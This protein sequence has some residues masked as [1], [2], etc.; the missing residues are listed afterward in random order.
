MP[1]PRPPAARDRRGPASRWWS[2]TAHTPRKQY[3][4]T[5]N[6]NG[7]WSISNIDVSALD[8]GPLTFT[9]TATDDQ[10]HSAEHSKT[11]TKDTVAPEVNVLGVTDPINSGNKTTTHANGTTDA[12]STI[13]VTAT[14]GTNTTAA[15]TGTAGD[16][17]TWSVTDIDVS[18]LTDGEI[19]YTIT[20]TDPAGN[21]TTVTRTATKDT[22]APTVDIDSVTDPIDLAHANSVTI[23][24][25][26]EAGATISVVITDGTNSTTATTTTVAENG[27]W[28]VSGINVSTLADGTITYQV[29]ITDGAF[30]TAQATQTAVKKTVSL[31]VVT[32]PVNSTN[33]T[34][35][36]ASGTGEAGATISLVVTDGTNT[37]QAYTTTIAANGTWSITGINVSSLADG[38]ITYRVTATDDEDNSAQSTKTATKDT[39]APTVA[40]TTVTN[41]ITSA[42]DNTVTIGGTGNRGAIDHRQSHRR[43]Q[44]HLQL[45]RHRGQQRHLGA[46]AISTSVPWPTAPSLS[47]PPPPTPRAT[48]PRAAITATK[49]AK[50]NGSLSGKVFVDANDNGTLDSGEHG[51][52]GV[53]VTLNGTDGA[54]NALPTQT[55]TTGA[56]RELSILGPG[57]RHLRDHSGPAA[58]GTRRRHHGRHPGRHRQ[59]QRDLGHLDR[60]HR[61]RH[62]IQLWR[63]RPVD[64]LCLDADVP[65]VVPVRHHPLQPRHLGLRHLGAVVTSIVKAST[66]PVSGSSVTFTVTFNQAVTG[67]DVSDFAIVASSGITGASI[68]SVTGSGTTYT[69]TVNVGGG[70]G[71]IGL[72]LADNDSIIDA[73]SSPLG[74]TGSGNGTFIGPSYTIASGVADAAISTVTSP[75]NNSQQGERLGQRHRRARRHDLVDRDRRH[76]YDQC[77]HGHGRGQRHLDHQRHQRQRLADG[78]L[79]F[80]IVSTATTGETS[81]ATKTATKDTVAPTGAVTAVTDPVNNANKANTSASGTGEVGATISL[82]VDGGSVT[83]TTYTAT[84][85]SN[86]TWSITGI[87]VSALPDGTITYTITATDAAGNTATSSKAALKDTVV[88][89]VAV[90]TVTDP[91]GLADHTNATAS[92]TGEVGATISLVVSDGTELDHRLYRHGRQNGTWTINGIDTSD[93]ADG[94]LTF[95]ATATDAGGNSATATKTAA[96]HTVTVLPVTSPINAANADQVTVSGTGQVGRQFHS[97]SPTAI[98]VHG[99]YRHGRRGRHLEH[100]GR[101]RQRPA[102]R[103]AHVHCDCDR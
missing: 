4:T 39:V 103:H 38:T 100:C 87:D 75:I 8:D 90:T 59:R 79:T 15:K 85:T 48:A 53:I 88:P 20:V 70:S 91:I 77:L 63:A 26:G 97:S 62:G 19:T 69:V 2:A 51:I 49:N 71:T 34:S 1:T 66:E 78:T 46:L 43:H 56:G 13:S 36:S 40:V 99:I 14:D 73:A 41:P 57:R 31:T 93:L 45:Q 16:L 25:T 92:G 60:R 29:T 96:K 30:N 64:R 68:S 89:A 11:V 6:S 17:G 18:A 24:G 21:S 67:V 7:T 55:A 52:A 101:R 102:R 12:G 80:K 83:S 47:P 95:T 27:T 65:G 5:I 35:T 84:V 74:G 10:E 50:A 54:G 23:S 58:E 61:G 81:Q 76:Q 72:K 98:S 94:T 9:A 42:N 37:T 82:V 86:G 22:V 3:T 32:N 28:S 33:A 44:H